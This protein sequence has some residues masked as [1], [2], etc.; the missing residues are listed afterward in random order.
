M[1][2]D[3]SNPV[4]VTQ[5]PGM[6][7]HPCFSPDRKKIAFTSI[8]KGNY[9]IYLLEIAS[10]KVQRLTSNP[11][12]DDY[13]CWSPDGKTVVWVAERNGKRDLYSRKIE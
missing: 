10:R 6:D 5:S 13:P 3:G 2:S 12:V 8:R 9:D 1:N 4:N 7:T 11:E